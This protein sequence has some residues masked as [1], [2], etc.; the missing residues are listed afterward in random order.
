MTSNKV[1]HRCHCRVYRAVIRGDILP[2]VFHGCS[3]CFLSATEYHH[4]DGYRFW[5]KIIPVCRGCH[6]RIHAQ[7]KTQSLTQAIASR[8]KGM[9]NKTQSL[10]QAIT[11]RE[12][13]MGNKTQRKKETLIQ[14]LQR[15]KLQQNHNREL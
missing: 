13:G 7:I 1:A 8:E 15:L 4:Y 3:F 14:A 2:A 9:G 6:R 10:T 12:K 11:S 5:W